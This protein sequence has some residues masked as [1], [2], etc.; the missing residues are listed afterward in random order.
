MAVKVLAGGAECGVAIGQS[1]QDSN[2]QGNTGDSS[3]ILMEYFT[4]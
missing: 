3:Q 1:L 2:G 4:I